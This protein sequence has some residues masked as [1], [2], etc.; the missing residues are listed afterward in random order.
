MHGKLLI[1]FAEQVVLCMGANPA[2]KQVNHMGPEGVLT[3]HS[4]MIA[5][6]VKHHSSRAITQY[7]CRAEGGYYIP[8][9]LPAGI[10]DG[11]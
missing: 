1:P 9:D 8:R 11:S 2:D 10:F 3:D 7:I 5:F 4:V 6:D